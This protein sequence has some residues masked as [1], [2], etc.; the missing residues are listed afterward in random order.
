MKKERNLNK[1]FAFAIAIAAAIL[2][3]TILI[4]AIITKR[5]NVFFY[6]VP[7]AQ[8]DSIAKIIEQN[9]DKKISV[10][11]IDDAI[12]LSRQQNKLK[13]ADI[14]I[15]QLDG[16]IQKFAQTQKKIKKFPQE[17][18]NG[19]TMSVQENVPKQNGKINY[20]PLLHDMYQI[21]VH[22]NYFS[23]S[24]VKKIE[25]WQDLEDLGESL[26]QK[27]NAPMTLPFADDKE[28]VNIFG[29]LTEALNS[30]QEYQKFYDNLNAA[31][32]KDLEN[33]KEQTATQN[34]NEKNEN[35]TQNYAET[36][37]YLKAEIENA[38]SPAART[39]KT[40]EKLLEN[41]IIRKQTLAQTLQENLFYVDNQICGI[42]L[43][44]LS[45]HRKI[46]KKVA[47]NYKSAYFPSATIT[48]NRKFCANQY[49]AIQLKKD[50]KLTRLV[51][52][53]SDS[54]QAELSASTGLAP[55]QKN[56]RVPDR[57]ADDARYWLAASKGILNPLS[58]AV[59]SKTAQTQV[60]EILRA[61]LQ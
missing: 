25:I 32:Y 58:C 56:C 17:I 59:P 60:A 1:F 11:Q 9:Y 35:Q 49:V 4:L 10:T 18:L 43:T 29:Q 5:T 22:W 61:Q 46:D 12:P 3:A 54:L 51:Q 33:Q 15:A 31:F 38:E 13:K 41:K 23:E 34:R 37:N 27:I 21:D 20:A 55:V 40:L 14:L 47:N 8:A 19:T 44:K 52:D 57:Q 28:F 16:E 30:P 42:F 2:V 24:P 36:I 53:L 39:I 6:N 50:K 26:K 7:Q 45:D 48:D